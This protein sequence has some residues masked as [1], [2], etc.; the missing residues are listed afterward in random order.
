MIILG[1]GALR[2]PAMTFIKE[3]TDAE[4]AIRNYIENI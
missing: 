1:S 4:K 2:V 3:L